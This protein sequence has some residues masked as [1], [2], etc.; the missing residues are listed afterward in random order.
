LISFPLK[1]ALEKF[2]RY[3]DVELR[4]IPVS[5]SSRFV[6]DFSRIGDFVDENTIC[7]AA[8][9]GSTFTGQFEDV[10]RLNDALEE[11]HR[12]HD[13]DIKIHVDAASGGFIAPFGFPDLKWDFALPR[14]TRLSLFPLPLIY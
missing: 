7:V 3:F 9:L 4:L 13:L 1:V 10:K 12:S 8:I 2:A 5:E 14:V 11:L 6:T